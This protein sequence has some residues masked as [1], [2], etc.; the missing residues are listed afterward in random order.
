MQ[1]EHFTQLIHYIMQQ[2]QAGRSP[3]AIRQQ[4]LAHYWDPH[5]VEAALQQTR[6]I[7]TQA[8]PQSTTLLGS[9]YKRFGFK[10]A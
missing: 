9:L 8:E 1:Q 5:M 7:P 6:T 4:L 10:K 2:K 3:D